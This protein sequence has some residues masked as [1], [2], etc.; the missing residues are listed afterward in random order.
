VHIWSASEEMA[1]EA[2]ETAGSLALRHR[3]DEQEQ[4]DGFFGAVNPETLTSLRPS[5]AEKLRSKRQP[6]WCECWLMYIAGRL[7]DET[8]LGVD[9]I[10]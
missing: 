10:D 5:Q 9:S 8:R 6:L 4:E 1:K 3:G 2:T 7:A